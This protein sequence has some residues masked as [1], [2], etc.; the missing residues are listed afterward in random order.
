MD[1][2][3]SDSPRLSIDRLSLTV[4]VEK[5][6][7]QACRRR[8]RES[9]PVGSGGML[10]R[11]SIRIPEGERER[12]LIQWAPYSQDENCWLRVEWNPAKVLEWPWLL[13][14][15]IVPFL[16]DGWEKTKLTRIDPCVDYP[17]VKMQELAYT[18]VRKQKG[19]IHYSPRGIETVYLGSTKSDARIRI[20]DKA[21]ELQQAGET[22]G[23]DLTRIEAQ[24]RSPGVPMTELC[25][26]KNPFSSLVLLQNTLH[27]APY[28][29]RLYVQE[30]ERIGLDAV[31][32]QLTEWERRSLKKRL[33]ESKVIVHPA[34][35]FDREYT[36]YCQRYLK[37]F[38]EI[39]H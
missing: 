23:Y 18:A 36:T 26:V 32:K 14:R 19:A 30:A 31:L 15:V 8:M 24:R 28:R 2:P 27:S 25:D 39:S 11:E 38:A 33:G 12:V 22:L 35:V 10:Y 4:R 7:W 5:G 17:F 37:C 1:N 13:K 9:G 29:Y 34:K 16:E 6:K 21:K 3:D 20:Y